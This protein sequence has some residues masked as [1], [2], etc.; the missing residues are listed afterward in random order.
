MN[1]N[2]HAQALGRLAKGKPKSITE[3]ERKARAERAAFARLH[4]RKHTK[5]GEQ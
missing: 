3:S 5:V 4:I 2:K 1:K